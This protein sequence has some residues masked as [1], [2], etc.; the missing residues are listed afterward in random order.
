MLRGLQRSDTWAENNTAILCLDACLLNIKIHFTDVQNRV[1][2][3]YEVQNSILK[4]KL[5]WVH[6]SLLLFLSY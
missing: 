4:I 6:L 5:H 2:K 1:G 3:N